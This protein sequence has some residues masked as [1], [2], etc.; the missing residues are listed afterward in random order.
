MS[1]I[2]AKSRGLL[3]VLVVLPRA[4]AKRLVH[5]S[6]AF[7]DTIERHALGK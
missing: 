1:A 2:I 6:E 4:T 5:V 3:G 7:V